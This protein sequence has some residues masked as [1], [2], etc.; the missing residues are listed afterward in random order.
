MSLKGK[1]LKI[2][3]QFKQNGSPN[4]RGQDPLLLC[5]AQVMGYG[6]RLHLLIQIFNWGVNFVE[7]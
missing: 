7:D 6:L 2:K 3:V 5:F 1:D 4:R